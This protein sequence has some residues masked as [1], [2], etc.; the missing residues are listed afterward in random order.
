LQEKYK[1]LYKNMYNKGIQ[2]DEEDGKNTFS[3]PLRV[4]IDVRQ[5][6]FPMIFLAAELAIN[7]EANNQLLQSLSLR[8]VH[9]PPKKILAARAPVSKFHQGLRVPLQAW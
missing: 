6:I 8:T 7:R 2:R 4:N 9:F 5:V 3:F 1:S